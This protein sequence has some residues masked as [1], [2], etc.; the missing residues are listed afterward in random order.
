MLAASFKGLPRT[1]VATAEFDGLRIQGEV[2]GKLL[3]EAGGDVRILRYN[4]M[5][6]AFIDRLGFVP[7]AEDLALEMVMVKGDICVKDG[8][9]LKKGVFEH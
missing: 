6:H 4:G 2:Y 3:R 5:V 9:P 8:I 1:L 7:Q